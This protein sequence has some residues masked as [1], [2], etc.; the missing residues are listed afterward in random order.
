MNTNDFYKELMSQYSFDNEK[1]KKNAV[2]SPSLKSR[3]N[4]SFKWLAATGAVAV[5][6]VVVGTSVFMG[7]SEGN[8]ITVTPSDTLTA[9]QRLEYARQ[10]Y[11]DAKNKTEE[12][13][14]YVTFKSGLTPN[15]MQSTLSQASAYG[16]I[17]VV[18]VYFEDK[19]MVT[20]SDEI[21]KL[22][23]SCDKLIS[24]VK[25][26]CPN[27]VFT[28][29]NDLEQVYI[30]ET[31][32]LFGDNFTVI[33]QSAVEETTPYVAPIIRPNPEE[34]T[35]T[36]ETTPP[37]TQQTTTTTPPVEEE[38]GIDISDIGDIY[39]N[40]TDVRFIS[41]DMLLIAQKTGYKCVKLEDDK[42]YEITS[43]NAEIPKL[44]WTDAETQ[45][46]VV[47]TN[48][49]EL[50]L[51]SIK[52]GELYQEGSVNF[53][54]AITDAFY[55]KADNTVYATVDGSVY[56][57]DVTDGQKIEK[58]DLGCDT[59][60]V[61]AA[62]GDTIYYASGSPECNSASSY[63]G[64]GSYS[65]STKEYTTY[66]TNSVSVKIDA[67]ITNNSRKAFA[68]VISDSDLDADENRITT[69][70]TDVYNPLTNAFEKIENTSVNGVQLSDD[71]KYIKC[72]DKV[73]EFTAAGM[74]LCSTN[75][76][77]NSQ[78]ASDKYEISIL[79]NTFKVA[80]LNN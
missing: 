41:D 31:E 21:G 68:V 50:F 48:T 8:P 28:V 9:E 15:E 57:I 4:S 38:T 16:T 11:E 59:A 25:I 29:L 46:A 20:G 40:V 42:F 19:T 26:K 27:N 63:E 78:T 30:V 70:I 18:S 43:V 13:D 79:N 49:N 45:S 39:K 23:E 54:A 22:F 52:D 32:D 56:K 60:V 24:A 34:E 10:A 61:I 64:I 17:K 74:S 76:N 77:F 73:Y 3:L 7:I 58:L 37:E 36:P 33:D 6:T 55:D 71:G 1:I 67:I 44:L 80:S 53:E 14:L 72:G 75:V 47:V 65:L 35:T 62:N 12:V 66:A 2:K 51:M 69:T 5:L